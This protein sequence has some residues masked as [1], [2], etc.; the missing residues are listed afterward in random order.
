MENFNLHLGFIK[1]DRKITTSILVSTSFVYTILL[2]FFNIA[3]LNIDVIGTTRGTDFT[4]E[5]AFIISG[6]GLYLG[7]YMNSVAM[8]S[9]NREFAIQ[10][11]SGLSKPKAFSLAAFQ[12]LFIVGTSL[13]IGIIASLA[14]T[15]IFMTFLK[16]ITGI[17]FVISGFSPAAFGLTLLMIGLQL[18][19]M[20]MNNG[21]LFYRAETI[22]I[23]NLHKKEAIVDIKKNHIL[24][25]ISVLATLSII[26]P[27]F[28]Y[29]K[30]GAGIEFLIMIESTS[31]ISALGILGLKQF[32]IPIVIDIL[33][34]KKFLNNKMKLLTFKELNFTI[35][36]SFALLFLVLLLP[37]LG[38][39]TLNT[40]KLGIPASILTKVGLIFFSL[41]VS[42]TIVFKLT[43][44]GMKRID[45]YKTL[46][47]LGFSKAEILKIIRDKMILFGAFLLGLPL[48]FGIITTIYNG[49]ARGENLNFSYIFL[50]ATFIL[51]AIA[52]IISYKI[53]EKNIIK[54]LKFK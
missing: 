23:I 4:I 21:G 8:I 27:I 28:A 9:R 24:A 45:S 31:F 12:S 33:C 47:A 44:D 20:I 26:L 50:G 39:L 14:L 30:L 34:T 19:V 35:K 38:L 5:L 37:Y 2:A 1:R 29:P 43:L 42:L 53:L 46:K 49:L 36:Q 54:N 15:P 7:W 3:Y 18:F 22:D 40:A 48:F 13:F 11:T 17:N 16:N 52:I 32:A 25:V 51:G 41:V 6:L 10:L